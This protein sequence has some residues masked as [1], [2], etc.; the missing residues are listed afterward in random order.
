MFPRTALSEITSVSICL[1]C[2]CYSV[3]LLKLAWFEIDL[4]DVIADFSFFF[5]FFPGGH[6]LLQKPIYNA[7][8]VKTIPPHKSGEGVKHFP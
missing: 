3:Y 2:C 7:T 5:F 8:I 1:I 6:L 4:V